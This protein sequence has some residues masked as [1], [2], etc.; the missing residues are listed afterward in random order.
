[1]LKGPV[2]PV[3]M[4]TRSGFNDTERLSDAANPSVTSFLPK[5]KRAQDI[6]SLEIRAITAIHNTV[7][8]LHPLT[9]ESARELH[10]QHTTMA[11]EATEATEATMMFS[12]SLGSKGGTLLMVPELYRCTFLKVPQPE[13]AMF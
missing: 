12:L 5:L 2:A 4:N 9:Q 6:I 1:M 13:K 3:L 8:Y 10:G 7:H 11:T